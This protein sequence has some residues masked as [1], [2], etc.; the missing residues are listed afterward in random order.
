M[1][2][3]QPRIPGVGTLHW[4]C[5]SGNPVCAWLSRLSPEDQKHAIELLRTLDTKYTSLFP[6][7]VLVSLEDAN[8]AVRRT[9]ARHYVEPTLRRL[10]VLFKR[11]DVDSPVFYKHPAL[12]LDVVPGTNG[13][14]NV[15]VIIASAHPLPPCAY[16]K[17]VVA[18]LNKRE[19]RFNTSTAE[20]EQY[21]GMNIVRAAAY[22]QKTQPW[23]GCELKVSH[24]FNQ[25]LVQL[26]IKRYQGDPLNEPACTISGIAKAL[27]IP[28]KR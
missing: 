20:I 26:T 1:I 2:S 24:Q 12:G 28:A 16:P 21:I 25:N 15:T 23:K 27:T 8:A 7:P 17:T 18:A 3:N 4:P 22:A 11:Y 13:T 6:E 19:V 9:V 5:A 10:R 14:S